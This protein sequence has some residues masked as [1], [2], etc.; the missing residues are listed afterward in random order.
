M[1]AGNG[2]RI[3]RLFRPYRLRLSWLL[4]MILFSI[5]L[6]RLARMP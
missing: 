4:T 6:G 3:V 1:S 2:G 5:F